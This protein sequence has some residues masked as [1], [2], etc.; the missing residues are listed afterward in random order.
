M[1]RGSPDLIKDNQ[2]KDNKDSKHWATLTKN[3]A[4]TPSKTKVLATNQNAGLSSSKSAGSTNHYSTV[5]VASPPK[6]MN[7]V[8]AVTPDNRKPIVVDGD[9]S[10]KLFQLID[11]GDKGSNAALTV[12]GL[13]TALTGSTSKEND[14]LVNFST[15]DT[16]NTAGK[17][18]YL[19]EALT[20]TRLTMWLIPIQLIKL[21]ERLM[22]FY[23]L[24]IP[25]PV[26][27]VELIPTTC[28]RVAPSTLPKRN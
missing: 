4:A 8:T 11:M 18:T 13:T 22:T 12:S 20:R 2:S 16:R 27:P 19:W 5:P 21:K 6:L 23:L 15:I 28:C 1:G 17:K 9:D 26:I 3:S 10:V 25:I 7:C 24:L 14:A